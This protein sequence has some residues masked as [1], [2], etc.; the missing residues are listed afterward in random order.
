MSKMFVLKRIFPLRKDYRMIVSMRRLGW[1]QR[2]ASREVALIM[3][4]LVKQR[5]VE[6]KNPTRVR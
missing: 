3:P 4:Y 2:L 5:R 1:S 6:V